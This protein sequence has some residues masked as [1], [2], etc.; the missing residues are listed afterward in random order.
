[1]PRRVLVV[2][3]H[4]VVRTGVRALLSAAPGWEV[5]GEASNGLQAL[6]KIPQMLPDVVLLDLTMPFMNG[7]E[8]A[9]K[10]REVAPNAKIVFFSMH[11]I[12]PASMAVKADGFVSKATASRD[13]VHVL[14][15][16]TDKSSKD[17]H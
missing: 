14:E 2:D 7:F 5:C 17:P 16:V 12:P 9:L 11:Q 3:D 15:D 8:T 13:L 10:I 6:Q 1:V 4:D